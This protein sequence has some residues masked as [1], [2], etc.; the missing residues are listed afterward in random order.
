MTEQT[1]KFVIEPE[2]SMEDINAR[3]KQEICYETLE[4]LTDV[5]LMCEYK[6]CNS[7]EKEINKLGDVLEKY[8]DEETKQKIIVLEI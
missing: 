2:L 3:I 5:K 4:E 1:D 6:E 7:V 8:I